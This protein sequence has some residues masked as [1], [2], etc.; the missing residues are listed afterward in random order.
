MRRHFH[1]VWAISMRT[2]QMREAITRYKYNERWGWSAIFGR[3]LVGFLEEY[4]SDFE[5]YDYITP[6]PLSWDQVR[7]GRSITRARWLR[8]P[9]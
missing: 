7:G 8:P 5:A 9:R 2:G 1:F 6:S 4:V 3:I